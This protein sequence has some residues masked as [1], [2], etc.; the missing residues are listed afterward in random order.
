[1]AS[2][3]SPLDVPLHPNFGILAQRRSS[4]DKDV[5]ELEIYEHWLEKA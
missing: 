1:M 4:S 3:A 2:P 5:L